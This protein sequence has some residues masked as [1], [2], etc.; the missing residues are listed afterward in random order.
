MTNFYDVLSVSKD[1]DDAELKKAYRSLSLK[2]HPDR[3]ND[4]DAKSRFQA[5]NEAYETLSDP[6]KRNQYDMQERFG[7]GG[8]PGGMHFSH[9]NGMEEF[10]DMNN[11]F[12][13]FF[14]G[15]AGV[16]PGMQQGF[17]GGPGVRVFHSGPGNFRAEFSSNFHSPPPAIHKEIQITLE[18]CYTG[19]SVPLDIDRW[20]II[21]NNKVME[22][23]K[24]VISIPKG[25]DEND[26]LVIKDKGNVIN[27]N[28]KGEIKVNIK[29]INNTIFTRQGLDL[30][31][32]KKISLKEALCGFTFD[33]PHLNGKT[34]SLNNKS[35]PTV[36][37]PGFK[38]TIQGLGMSRE[39]NTG[40][41]IVDLEIDF[42]ESLTESQVLTLSDVL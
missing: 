1:A 6:G 18:Q 5:I 26:S 33:I 37:K 42:P 39:G 2:Y 4:E 24:L 28:L 22:K 21:N 29:I 38:K 11:I 13:A 7:G 12:Q 19:C 17:P 14:G 10:Q 34:F 27:D 41:L 32:N 35:N 20:I 30:I 9:T 40:N 36:V 3:N 31:L 23:E 16:F 15:G 8:M 25:M